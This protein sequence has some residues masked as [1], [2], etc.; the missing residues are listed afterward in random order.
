MPKFDLED[1][2]VVDVVAT[3]AVTEVVPDNVVTLS[4]GVKVQFIKPLTPFTAQQ[5]VI[6]SFNNINVDAQGRVKDNMTSQEQLATAKKMY[7][8]NSALIINGLAEGALKVYGGL[9]KDNRWLAIMKINPA[10]ASN[11]PFIDFND[12]LHLEFLYLFYTGFINEEDYGL[13][14][15]HLL[16]Q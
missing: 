12:Q 10:I 7:D 6:L 3:N 11:H 14:S 1:E 2:K 4:S 13:L 16:G 9:P 5:I 15:K 8:F